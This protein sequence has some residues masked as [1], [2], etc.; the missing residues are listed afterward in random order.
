MPPHVFARLTLGEV[1]VVLEGE[2][3]RA[4]Q[5]LVGR[6]VAAVRALSQAFG[7]KRALEGIV[8][9]DAPAEIS[10]AAARRLRF[11]RP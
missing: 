3:H 8:D 11:W 4:R 2:R 10:A 9:D 6:I 7:G 1:F 5:E